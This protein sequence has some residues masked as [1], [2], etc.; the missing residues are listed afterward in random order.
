MFQFVP[1]VSLPWCSM[2]SRANVWIRKNASVMI[3]SAILTCPG[4]TRKLAALEGPGVFFI[5]PKNEI[6]IF[7]IFSKFYFQFKDYTII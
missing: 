1:D 4:R 5:I 7:E 6:P 2:R 3:R